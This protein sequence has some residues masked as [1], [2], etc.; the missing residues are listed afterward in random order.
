MKSWLATG[1]H[2]MVRFEG[3]IVKVLKH[4]STFIIGTMVAD[5]KTFVFQPSDK[6][7]TV[8]QSSTPTLHSLN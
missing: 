8:N 3:E 6:H 5:K 7:I 4:N 1:K 2:P